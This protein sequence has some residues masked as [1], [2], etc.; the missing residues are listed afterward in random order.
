MPPW[1][2]LGVSLLVSHYGRL[3]RRDT[4]VSLRMDQETADVLGCH[5]SPECARTHQPVTKRGRRLFPHRK[6]QTGILPGPIG[7]R[8]VGLSTRVLGH[9]HVWFIGIETISHIH[10]NG[11]ITV[12]FHAFEGP[13]KILRLFGVGTPEMDHRQSEPF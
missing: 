13:P 9:I 3:L 2:F 1:F 12:M 4:R 8:C 5:S 6:F 11:R 10:E 7:Q